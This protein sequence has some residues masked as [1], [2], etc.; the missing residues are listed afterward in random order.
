MLEAMMYESN[1]RHML[2]AEQ[3]PR[4]PGNWK[5]RCKASRQT[6]ASHIY[7]HM[8]SPLKYGASG[9]SGNSLVLTLVV[10]QRPNHEAHA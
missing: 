8:V 2:E 3:T 6:D 1:L 9:D 4:S 5:M 7:T 10:W